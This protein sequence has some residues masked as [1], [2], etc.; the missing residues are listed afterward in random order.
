MTWWLGQSPVVFNLHSLRISLFHVPFLG[1]CARLKW[2]WGDGQDEVKRGHEWAFHHRD[3]G[4]E[5][6]RMFGNCKLWCVFCNKAGNGK[7]W[8]QT[9]QQGQVG[10]DKDVIRCWGVGDSCTPP[11][12]P[13]WARID[14]VRL[15]CMTRQ[16]CVD[17]AGSGWGLWKPQS[18]KKESYRQ[19]AWKPRKEIRAYRKVIEKGWGIF[20]G[21]VG[22]C[23]WLVSWIWG[24]KEWAP[25]LAEAQ[26]GLWAAGTDN[27]GGAVYWWI[28]SLPFNSARFIKGLPQGWVT[29]RWWMGCRRHRVWGSG[30]VCWVA[31]SCPTFCDPMDCS[32]PGPPFMEFSRQEYWSGLP[33]PSPGDLPTPGIEPSSPALAG[34]F[35]SAEP[36]GKPFW[37]HTHGQMCDREEWNC[38]ACRR[39][40]GQREQI[41]ESPAH[42]W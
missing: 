14:P 6:H 36:P 5:Q 40:V 13:E 31:K 33:F 29:G 37:W 27:S 30:D 7:R 34:G 25:I 22:L 20:W 1:L 35:F 41:C 26:Q 11:P 2:W 39:G 24:G 18:W 9:G 21:G 15:I 28:E 32:P 12:T 38:E 42:N 10:M 4:G 16:L 3:V 8:S 19:A 23:G 17:G